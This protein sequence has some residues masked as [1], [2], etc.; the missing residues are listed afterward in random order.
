MAAEN[1]ALKSEVASLQTVCR[2]RASR[3][4]SATTRVPWKLRYYVGNVD[5]TVEN[6]DTTLET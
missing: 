2:R 1:E 5:T 6:V 4:P 3:R